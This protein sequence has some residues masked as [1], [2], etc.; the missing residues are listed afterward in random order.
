MYYLQPSSL[1]YAA[2]YVIFLIVKCASGQLLDLGPES[3]IR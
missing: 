2:E 1:G 3:T